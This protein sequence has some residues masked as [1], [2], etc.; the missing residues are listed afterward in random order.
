MS[1]NMDMVKALLANQQKKKDA[2][3]TTTTQANAPDPS[4][5]NKRAV[6]EELADVESKLED[7]KKRRI[8]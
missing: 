1:S 2:G 4:T 5:P 8:V 7:A 6:D 3:N